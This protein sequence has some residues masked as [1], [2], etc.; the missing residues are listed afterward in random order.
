MSRVTGAQ[1]VNSTRNLFFDVCLF[2]T[3]V[4]ERMEECIVSC[5]VSSSTVCDMSDAIFLPDQDKLVKLGLIGAAAIVR[6]KNNKI[7]VRII[8]VSDENRTIYKNTKLG[9]LEILCTEIE[10]KNRMLHVSTMEEGFEGLNLVFRGINTNDN[11]TVDEKIT[12]KKL[13]QNYQ[14]VFS[15]NKMDLGCCKAVKHEIFLKNDTP[16]KLPIRR[17]PMGFEDKV[18]ELVNDLL[19]KNVIQPSTSPWNS[20]LVIVPKKNGDIRLCVDFRMLNSVTEKLTYPIPDTQ[21][22][23]DTL[24]G[25]KYFSSIDLSSAYYQCELSDESKKLT[26]FATRR[27]HFEFNRMPFGLC[28]APFT[29]QRMMNL[30]LTSENWQKCLIYLDHVLIFGRTFDEHLDRL[31]CILQKIFDAGIKL[32]PEKCVFFQKQLTFLGHVISSEGIKTDPQKV[33]AIKEWRRPCNVEQMRQFLGFANYYRRFIRHYAEF[34]APLEDIMKISCQ[35][36]V[37]LGKKTM[38]KWNDSAAKSFE[39]LKEALITAPS[40]E[41]SPS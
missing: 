20:P 24:N 33:M 22:L 23:L 37:N 19:E 3:T 8:N 16:I 12:V 4:L 27:G 41:L 10:E 5:Y 38:L 32:S 17:V 2:E 36:N 29:F 40:F 25:E 30:V 13:F 7:P 11:L 9:F 6:S 14:G 34:S 26:A 1:C 31:H 39:S 15:A 21:Q 35:G 28:G 18:D